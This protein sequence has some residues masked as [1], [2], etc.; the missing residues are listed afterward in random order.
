MSSLERVQRG[1][2]FIEAHL[3]VD[4][5]LD[6]VAKAAGM[7]CWHFQ[8]IF[9]ALTQET[10]KTYIRSRRF[11][12][13]LGLLKDTD[14]PL[15]DIALASGFQTHESFTRAFKDCFRI[16]PNHYRKAGHALQF[17]KK[18]QFDADYLSHVHHHHVS[19]EPVI[20]QRPALRLV[21]LR[22]VFFGVDSAKNNVSKKLPPLWSAFLSR[23]HEVEHAVQG[24]C[25]GVMSPVADGSGRL[26]YLAGIEVHPDGV[27]PAGMTLMQLP[28]ARQ[29]R[30]T[31]RGPVQQLDHT[32][33]YIYG[34]WLLTSG[35][36]VQDQWD[37]EI[38]GPLYGDGGVDSVMHYA[39]TLN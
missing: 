31:H 14:L 39:M 37:L 6:D 18:A 4:F 35:H 19:L 25:Y 29:A 23:L 5:A 24:C 10:L 28:A 17:V 11:S 21:G 3:E 9:K 34:N 32:V 26:Q 33:N 1:I 27:P 38:Y 13:A 8:R 15:L 36:T 30:F 16:T 20:E 7:S 22:T 12:R 2:N